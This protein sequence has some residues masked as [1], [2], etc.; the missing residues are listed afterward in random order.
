MFFPFLPGDS[1][2]FA[3][4]FFAQGGGFNI[5]LLLGIAWAAAIIGDQCN[6][7]IGHFFGEFAMTRGRVQHGAAGVG[8]TRSS[9]YVPLK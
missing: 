6:F 8:A 1:L 9:K 7:M 5:F 2:L 4:G 3:S